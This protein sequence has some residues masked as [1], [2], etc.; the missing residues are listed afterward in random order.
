MYGVE[1]EGVLKHWRKSDTPVMSVKVEHCVS[2]IV[3]LTVLKIFICELKRKKTNTPKI[4]LW[5]LI[6]QGEIGESDKLFWKKNIT[7]N[8]NLSSVMKAFE[9]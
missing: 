1:L 6:L 9:I 5:T 2:E 8:P 7:W 4:Y 3:L